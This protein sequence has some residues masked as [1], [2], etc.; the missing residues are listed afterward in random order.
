VFVSKE[1]KRRGL[2]EEILAVHATG[3]PILVG[4]S[5]VGESDDLA[6]ALQEKG[7]ACQV[8]N[9][10]NDELEA[11]IVARAGAPGAVTISTNM[12]GRGTDIRL[13]G[14]NEQR[15]DTVVELGGLYVIGTNRYESRRVDDQLRGRSGRQGDPGSSRF[16]ISVQD[17]LLQRF[18]IDE[19]TVPAY[20]GPTQDEP[21]DDPEVSREIAH[22][23]RVIEGQNLE[24][25]RTLW[26]YSYALDKQRRIL[27]GRRQDLLTGRTSP[28]LLWERAPGRYQ[29]LLGEVG[30]EALER[31]E[32]QLTLFHI[33]RC[34][35]EYLD[36]VAHIR[37]GIHLISGVGH[38][39][40]D[41]YHR[42]VGRAFGDLIAT[43]D[44]SIVETF[45]SATVTADGIDLEKEGLKGPSSTWTY[46][47]N[48]NPFD[49]WFGR[50]YKTVTHS[51]EL[52]KSLR[53]AVTYKSS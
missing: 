4:T 42:Q 5:S 28:S 14:E 20:D 51:S 1:A 45:L 49:G 8:L 22:V 25:R 6:R 23:Q 43:I 18:G 9:A 3:R 47:I 29:E 11:E 10:K 50:V 34:W 12:A 38:S 19:F 2:I 16:F 32:R 52:L 17:D 41:T 44:D 26:Q 33:D 30:P 21:I 13:G 35:A 53:R 15:R 7:V 37:E 48:D 31:V 27:H 39:A 24:I 46:L 36:H 40:L